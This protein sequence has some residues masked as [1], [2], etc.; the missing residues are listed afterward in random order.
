MFSF[1]L[2]NTVAKNGKCSMQNVV[3]NVNKDNKETEDL[4]DPAA[5]HYL[6]IRLVVSSLRP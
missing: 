5:S 4:I 2:T 3:V 6:S 1:S